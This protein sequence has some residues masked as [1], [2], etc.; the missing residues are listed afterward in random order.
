M[1][2]MGAPLAIITGLVGLAFTTRSD[3]LY[4][5]PIGSLLIMICGAM[6]YLHFKYL[7]DDAQLNWDKRMESLPLAEMTTS[8]TAMKE[9]LEKIMEQFSEQHDVV[10]TTNSLLEQLTT[11]VQTE[12][13]T[14]ISQ[15][16]NLYDI[17]LENTKETL[18]DFLK[19]QS[20][21]AEDTASKIKRTM[22]KT[23]QALIEL[24][25]SLERFTS[26]NEATMKKAVDGF[27]Q[28][29]TLMNETLV[30]LTSISNQDYELLKG[31]L[32]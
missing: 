8:L 29:E 31:M 18:E 11:T 32:K 21:L 1:K 13:Q 19:N 5:F 3:I 17:I 26:Q 28:F 25:S 9:A 6:T 4:S 16:Q 15:Q 30:Q 27:A 23:N 2:K 7:S 24:P 20:E 12:A 22:N 14:L 10:L